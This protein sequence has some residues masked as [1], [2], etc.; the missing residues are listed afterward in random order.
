M[1][2]LLFVVGLLSG[3]YAVEDDPFGVWIEVTRDDQ[4]VKNPVTWTIGKDLVTWSMD[5]KI[6]C[7]FRIKNLKQGDVKQFTLNHVLPKDIV[8]PGLEPLRII[9]RQRQETLEVCYSVSQLRPLEF[10]TD[11]QRGSYLVKLKRVKDEDR[12]K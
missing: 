4:P 6:V 9:Y 11:H 2:Q 5:G 7:E 3:V 8:I 10:K 12:E 1:L